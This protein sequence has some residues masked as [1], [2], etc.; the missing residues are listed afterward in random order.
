MKFVRHSDATAFRERVDEFLLRHEVVHNVILGITSR[1]IQQGEGYDEVFLAHVEN[2]AG[3]VVAAAMRTV[4]HGVILSRITD[5]NAILL[6]ANEIADAYDNLPS[7][8]GQG[9]DSSQFAELWKQHHGQ[10]YAIKME[11]GQYRLETVIPPQNVSGEARIAN[12]DDFDMLVDWLIKFSADTGLDK[13]FYQADAEE[14]IRRKLDK[15]ILGGIRIWMDNGQPVSM[16]AATRESENGG[17]VSLV[18]TPPELRGR[19][20][21]SAVTAHVSQAILD[22]GKKFALLSTD[23]SFPTSNKIYQAIGYKFV[24]TQRRIE[25]ENRD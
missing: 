8:E 16:A 25:F 5:K 6:L 17:N 15:P 14:N 10:D 11:L 3:D 12:D 18:Y 9:D 7:V 22:A 2:E 21:A 1:I 24:G 13:N 20:Y 4:P 19:G 23:M